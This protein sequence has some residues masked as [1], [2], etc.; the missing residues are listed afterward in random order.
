MF[1]WHNEAAKKWDERADFW[2]QSS[3]DMWDHGSRSTIIP[4]LKEYIQPC[5]ILDAGCGDGYGSY[6]LQQQGFQVTGIDVSL[7]M[8]EKAKSRDNE[9][10]VQ[11]LQGDIADLPLADGI[12]DAI[13]AINSI[14]WTVNPLQVLKEFSRV[15]SSSGY[16][17]IGI[18]GPTA[19]PRQNSFQRLYGENVICNT[20][21]PWELEKLAQENGY[22]V[23]NSHGVYKREVTPN[24]IKGLSNEL[25]QALSFMWVF[26]FQKK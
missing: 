2:N 25:R 9:K 6:L 7:K 24:S 13:I 12:F 22:R 5:K 20:M 21:M 18:L 23:V 15:V 3:K 1:E 19:A 17:C 10:M 8:I 14:E 11:F 4:F 26:I 16:L